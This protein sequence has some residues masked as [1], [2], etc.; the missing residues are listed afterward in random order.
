M[1][2]WK[3]GV[4]LIWKFCVILH[5]LHVYWACIKDYTSI[6]VVIDLCKLYFRKTS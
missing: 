4:L 6:A 3:V 5:W 2:N 1:V